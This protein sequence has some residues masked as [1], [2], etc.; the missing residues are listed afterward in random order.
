MHVTVGEL[1]DAMQALSQIINRPRQIPMTA[2]Y[3]VAKLH[4]QLL[5]FYKNNAFSVYNDLVKQYGEEKFED[6]EKTKPLG[7]GLDE[8]SSNFATFREEWEKAREKTL[9]IG[10]VHPIT[11][12]AFGDA[13]ERGIEA[14]EFAF[15]GPF[16]TAPECDAPVE[17]QEA[18]P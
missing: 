14:N 9:D 6:A 10:K 2:K 1:Y 11:L 17:A 16:V 18:N 8:H 5:P 13:V 15:L 4:A 3:R 12:A 7:W